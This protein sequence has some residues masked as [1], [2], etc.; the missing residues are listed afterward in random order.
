MAVVALSAA[1]SVAH[2]EVDTLATTDMIIGTIIDMRVGIGT[3]VLMMHRRRPRAFMLR[4]RMFIPRE[5]ER[6][7]EK[8]KG[9]GISGRTMGV[10]LN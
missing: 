5:T 4:E 3:G 1:C 8:G 7:N 6:G 9:S 2:V 10:E